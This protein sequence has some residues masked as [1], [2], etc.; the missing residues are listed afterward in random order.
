MHKH[1][2]NILLASFIAAEIA[3]L[4]CGMQ[5]LY[6]CTNTVWVAVNLTSRKQQRLLF[7]IYV[8]F[9]PFSLK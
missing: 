8:F 4:K 7:I 1:S 5:A 6:D 3:V 9:L 2:A